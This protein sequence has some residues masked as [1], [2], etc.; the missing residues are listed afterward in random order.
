MRKLTLGLF[1][2]LLFTQLSLSQD[3]PFITKWQADGSG[4]I[5]FKAQTAG[6]VTYTAKFSTGSGYDSIMGT[7][8]KP[9][10]EDA[11]GFVS[12]SG[13]PSGVDVELRLGPQNLMAVHMYGIN[14]KEISQWGDVVWSSMAHAFE[15]SYEMDVT[16]TDKPNLSQ[17]TDMSFM[18]SQCEK[19]TGPNNINDWDV[20]N[21]TNMRA[22]FQAA[23]LFNQPLNDWDV[24]NVTD[25]EWMF[26]Y[27]SSFNQ[28]LDQWKVHNVISMYNIFSGASSFDQNLGSW[29]LHLN[30]E[31]ASIILGLDNSGISCENYQYSLLG[32]ATNGS[33]PATVSASGLTYGPSADSVRALLIANGWIIQGDEY[34]EE[35]NAVLPVVFGD[36][37]AILKGGSLIVNWATLT[38][39]NNDYF[40]VE[41]STDGK[42]FTSIG[43]VSSLAKDGNSDQPLEYTF[44]KAVSKNALLLGVAALALAVGSFVAGRRKLGAMLLWACLLLGGVSVSCSKKDSVPL[45]EGKDIYVRI[46][47]VDK[48]GSY[49]YSKVV[50]V[51]VEN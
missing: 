28:P 48:D 31:L 25:M 39:L 15:N 5:S 3:R 51:I 7:F 21:V 18:F 47:Q 19:L 8:N 22:M 33:S 37:K 38:E 20:S 40:E 43:K 35:C 50:K 10:M 6:D 13:L 42:T 45:A 26:Y 2:A 11:E 44:S 14:F 9:T 49:K 17:V 27:A 4:Q 41:V 30:N 29:E 32:W 1:V 34:D 36:V 24:S 46:K 12:I 16:A 23:L